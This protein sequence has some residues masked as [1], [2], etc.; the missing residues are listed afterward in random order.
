MCNKN[1]NERITE[2]E[3]ETFQFVNKNSLIIRLEIA[4]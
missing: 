4:L 1:V 2:S 3:R